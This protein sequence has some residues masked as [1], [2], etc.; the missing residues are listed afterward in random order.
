[1]RRYPVLHQRVVQNDPVRRHR[2]VRQRQHVLRHVVLY[3]R[4]DLLPARQRRRLDGL[5]LVLHADR[6]A[7]HLPAGLSAALRGAHPVVS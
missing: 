1:V 6:F 2:Y 4:P 5:S 7:T 3:E